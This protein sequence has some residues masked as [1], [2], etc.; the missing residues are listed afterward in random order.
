MLKASSRLGTRLLCQDGPLAVVSVRQ[1]TAQGVASFLQRQLDSRS[2]KS[3]FVGIPLRDPVD[4]AVIST[5]DDAADPSELPRATDPIRLS[6][7]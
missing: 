6:I 5:Y 1:A 3:A 2:Q 7:R 4:L